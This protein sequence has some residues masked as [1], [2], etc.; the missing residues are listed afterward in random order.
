MTP[1]MSLL[2]PIVLSAVAVFIVSMIVHMAMPWHKSDYGNVPNDDAAMAAIQSLNLA[3]DD[4]AVPNPHLPGGGKN[5]DFIA[6]FERGPTFHLTLMPS[7]GMNMGKLMGTWLGFMLLISAIAGWVTGSI[8]GPGGNT[9]AVFHYS[10]I[11]TA[12][13]YGFGAWPLS[14]WYH[15]KWSTS[16]KETFDA[17]LYGLASGA[18]FMVMWP[19]L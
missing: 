4:Y 13:S 14:I 2:L 9:H 12:C 19:K 11:I 7:G 15:R 5:P 18:V 17:I 16:F 1:F 3:P 10:A 6:K 8:V